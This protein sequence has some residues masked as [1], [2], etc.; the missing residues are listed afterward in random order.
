MN[1]ILGLVSM[2]RFPG[3]NPGTGPF[4]LTARVEEAASSGR[5]RIDTR[6]G[7]FEISSHFSLKPGDVL[8]LQL[9]E[10]KGTSWVFRCLEI[11]SV[12]TNQTVNLLPTM[13]SALIQRGLPLM[14]EKL[15]FLEK[16][17]K[18]LDLETSETAKNWIV[19][20]DLK[21]PEG[22]AL[23]ERLKP[24]LRWEAAVE[25]GHA[26]PFPEE[27]E[28]CWDLWNALKDHSKRQWIT[29]PFHFEYL[30][31]TASGLIHALIDPLH[32]TPIFWTLTTAAFKIP[33]QL[34]LQKSGK[35]TV[36][37]LTFY[38]NEDYRFFSKCAIVIP[39]KYQEQYILKVGMKSKQESVLVRSVNEKI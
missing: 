14:E 3:F 18:A 7:R 4:Y 23:A 28:D 25:N 13:A 20:Q 38:N 9:Q 22:D 8:Q 6:F 39:D 12:P 33:L 1:P 37:T 16:K 17:W 36:I 10:K 26:P 11:Q 29:I 21:A 31:E 32:S 35:Y 2:P 15:K 30:Q 19:N 24:F 27:E 34:R 5:W